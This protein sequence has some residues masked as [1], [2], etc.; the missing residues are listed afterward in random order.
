MNL[1][2]QLLYTL[3]LVIG[4]SIGEALSTYVFGSLK[5]KIFYIIE[6]ILFVAL[7]VT[8]LNTLQLTEGYLSVMIYFVSGV[9][10]IIFVRGVITGL[11]LFSEKVEK[12]V[13]KRKD[14]YDYLFGLKKA[15]E[16]RNFSKHE[17]KRIA[18]EIGFKKNKIE[19]VFDFTRKMD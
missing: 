8:L 9:L 6:I 14:E 1:I 18:K 19:R 16:R 5:K 4:I 12:K 15:L 13:I 11:G 17:I 2:I 3:A 7:I 10:V